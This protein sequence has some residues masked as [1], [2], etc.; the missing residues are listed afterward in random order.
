MDYKTGFFSQDNIFYED[1]S[2]EQKEFLMRP[3]AEDE[4]GTLLGYVKTI[5]QQKE[6]E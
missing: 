5:Y 6:K 3:I 2:P 4:E 1:G